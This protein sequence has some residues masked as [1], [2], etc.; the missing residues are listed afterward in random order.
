MQ[1][2]AGSIQRLRVRGQEKQKERGEEKLWHVYHR[3]RCFERDWG[4]FIR[5]HAPRQVRP[6]GKTLTRSLVYSQQ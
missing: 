2:N 5:I 4:A 6:P 1:G 3:L